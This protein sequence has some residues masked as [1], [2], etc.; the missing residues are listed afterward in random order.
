MS[1]FSL[2]LVGLMGLV[3]A[4]SASAQL[5]AYYEFEQTSDTEAYDSS[6]KDN[7][8]IISS[9]SDYEDVGEPNWIEG[10]VGQALEFNDDLAI[11]LP[12][13]D[14]GLRSDTG[15][16]AFWLLMEQETLS[17]IN[18]IWWGGD[19]DTGGGFG[20][21]NEMHIHV[22]SAASGI[23]E[24][25]E[26]AFHGQNTPN[27][28]HLFS[29][30]NKGDDPATEPNDPI[31]MNDGQ[32]HHVVCTWGNDDGNAKM[33]HNG[34]LLHELAQ[35]SRNY[36]LSFMVV[37]CMAD[38][39]R[40]LT[41][42]LDDVQVYGRA[43]TPE[44]VNDVMNATL[45]LTLPASLPSPANQITEVALDAQMTWMM[46]DTADTH[47]VYFGQSFDDVNDG[48]A[49]A[50]EG[51][52][53]A[54]FDPGALD[55]LQTYYW[56]VDEVEADGV[57]VHRGAVWGF[58]TRN[59]EVIDDFEA[60]TN[61]SPDRIFDAWSDGWNNPDENGAV[62]GYAWTDDEIEAGE[63]FAETETVRSG[64]QAM[65]LFFDT[66]QKICEA[67]LSLDEDFQDW[68]SMGLN[69]LSLW[70]K[71]YWALTGSHHEEPAGVYNITASGADI[72]SDYDECYFV[73][74]EMT[75][76]VTI[77]A[78]IDSLV[79]TGDGWAK[80]GIMI[81]DTLDAGAR[82]TAL[83]FTPE[84]GTRLQRRGAIDGEY[85]G[86]DEETL[87]VG[88]PNDPN[89]F[90]RW[91]K[92]VKTGVVTRAYTSMNGT[93]W[94]DF[95][96]ART[97]VSLSGSF[98]VG[99]A[100]TSHDITAM[101]DAV[102]SNVT[103]TGNGSDAEWSTADVGIVNNPAEPVFVML[104]DQAVVY[105]D[106][107]NATQINEWAQWNI[108]LQAFA[109]QGL[110]LAQVTQLTLG[111]G[112][113]GDGSSAG[114]TGTLYVDDIRLYRP[115]VPVALAVENG[116]FELPG[117]GELRDFNEVPGWSTDIP[118]EDSGIA[119]NGEATDGSY[120]AWT[121]GS[122]PALWNLTDVVVAA[123]DL[124][125]LTVDARNTWQA[126]TLRLTLYY[127]DQDD[128]GNDIRVP[129]VSEDLAVTDSM[130]TLS[131]SFKSNDHRAAIG[132]Q[133]GIELDNVTAETNSF[134]GLDNIR[135]MLQESH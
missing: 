106:E 32:W 66:D 98:Y 8:G 31:L 110:D 131:L 55:Y 64:L 119:E 18:T 96:M 101:T 57:T 86:T 39:G 135:L 24:G 35:G 123:G 78:H 111:V 26:L 3:C 122:D 80:A 68:A 92:I 14:M 120:W 47:T 65:P 20:P 94:E 23:W 44:E 109:D 21:E 62:V 19:N 103:L 117:T 108:P 102:I 84:N 5:L 88:D 15:A 25:G 33:Y 99:L 17:G 61:D 114:G 34:V 129:I 127:Q 125:E 30:P 13:E 4:S 116:S 59:F 85:L 6:G 112:Q 83:F 72:W 54:T 133:L 134:I 76:N 38:G 69:D 121:K 52:T 87:Y 40:T 9:A 67:S 60:Y 71:G 63:N 104:N 2:V 79:N 75:G 124:I 36:P 82:N 37:G 22:E 29:D 130:Q 43:L 73:Y 118:V 107:P 128:E 74:K 89:T 45:A 132:S 91:L 97:Y 81:R 50:A 48:T 12:A 41:G 46:G 105:H 27:N 16:V 10:Q 7:H 28:F 42:V 100:L 58:T 115:S 113:Q 49:L 70:I 11:M 93:T 90:P 53:E 126:D 1:R 77:V 56:R 95:P 51:L